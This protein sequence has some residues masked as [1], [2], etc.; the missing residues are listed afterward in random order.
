MIYKSDFI[1]YSEIEVSRG[2]YPFQDFIIVIDTIKPPYE[3]DDHSHF[4]VITC[5]TEEIHDKSIEDIYFGHFGKIEIFLGLISNIG[6]CSAKL[7]NHVITCPKFCE[8]TTEFQILSKEIYHT[9]TFKYG[10][11]PSDFI[12]INLNSN[13]THYLNPVIVFINKSLS[14]DSI[15]QKILLLYA[16]LERIASNNS[17]EYVNRICPDCNAIQQTELKDVRKYIKALLSDGGASQ[18]DI[19]LFYELRNKIA[20]GSGTRNVKFYSEIRRTILNLQHIVI[21]FV[22][23]SL[24]INQVNSQTSIVDLPIAVYRF[25][26]N[27]NNIIELAGNNSACISQTAGIS[28]VKG[29]SDK[30]LDNLE[31]RMGIYTDEKNLIF[32]RELRENYFPILYDKISN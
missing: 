1:L 29:M 3:T 30:A 11:D 27:E 19:K 12:N 5:E 9:R 16:A 4:K 22:C 31:V 25:V 14:T 15:E 20:H 26:R 32:T 7:F 23:H 21:G 8:L 18:A 6:Y 24:Q 2:I 13:E 10:I 28:Q 17:N